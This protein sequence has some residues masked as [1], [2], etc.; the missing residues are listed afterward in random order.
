MFHCSYRLSHA[1]YVI[2]LWLS[3]LTCVS[4]G[5]QVPLT[6][7]MIAP[8][9]I[10]WQNQMDNSAVLLQDFS[11][12]LSVA[13]RNDAVMRSDASR[14][15]AVLLDFG[16]ELHGGLEIYS[17]I[18]AD[19]R[20]VRL[21]V[22]L[23][24][25]VS[26]AMS[27]VDDAMSTATNDHSMRDF[28]IA[29]PWLGSVR[30]GNSGFRFARIDLLDSCVDY[31]LRAVKAVAIERDLPY[32]GAFRSDNQRLNQIWLTGAR[33][34]QLCMQEYLWDGI[35]RDRLVW[36]GDINPEVMTINNVFGQCD[37]VK[38]SLDFARD[39]T[40]LP[41]WMNGM[42]SYSL[43]W[44]ITQRDLYLY[45]GDVDYL[46]QQHRYLRQL[47]SQ[48]DKQV[49]D[50]G[51]EHFDGVRFIDWPTSER[52]DVIRSGLQ[53]LSIMAVDAALELANAIDDDELAERCRSLLTRLRLPKHD[54]CANAQAAALGVLSGLCPDDVRVIEQGGASSCSAFYG[55]YMLEALARGGKWKQAVG[56][57][58]NYWGRMLD[59]GATSF[60]E[61]L[62]YDKS[63]NV[64]RIDELVP[65]GTFDLHG[66][67]GDYCYVGHR[68]SLCHGWASGPTP[69]LTRYI[70]GVRPSAPGCRQLT[71][72][73]HLV[74]CSDVTGAV[75]TP[76]GVVRLHHRMGEDGQIHSVIDAPAEIKIIL[77][78]AIQ[79]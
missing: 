5:A 50:N 68:M 2:V 49:D 72:E 14:Q 60:W 18:R 9:R 1:V 55:Y 34:V 73:P 38:R 44:I 42:C 47:L 41:G 53:S 3:C 45:Q 58:E 16:R 78:N 66:Q 21:R 54:N 67:G 7:H 26:E 40:P 31:R 32:L 12:Q 43:W 25:S 46:M 33:T 39:G 71:I 8:K 29:A 20:P 6:E 48:I 70:L 61:E 64:A 37:V 77:K 65:D 13:D 11:G 52:D 59:L 75:P 74:G 76:M 19:K 17:G 36:I 62:E 24:E 30:V 28:V 23:G 15:A 69:W 22:R 35:K 57:I 10:L 51:V 4:G 27:D 63:L 56:L 79:D